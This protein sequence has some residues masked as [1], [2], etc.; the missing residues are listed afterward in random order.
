MV[1]KILC[2]VLAAAALLLFVS[3][4][5]SKEVDTAALISELKSSDLFSEEPEQVDSDTVNNILLIDTSGCSSFEFYMT[6]GFTG[7]EFGV[8][9]CNSGD[10]ADSLRSSL[11]ARKSSQ[12]DAYKDYNQEAIP[13]IEHTVIEVSGKYVAYVSADDYSKAQEIVDKYFK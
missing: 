2:A 13:R 9:T 4:G 7:E 10:D 12:Y 1:K 8:F 11:E 5:S 6:T 3:C